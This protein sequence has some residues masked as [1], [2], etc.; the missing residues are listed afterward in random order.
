MLRTTSSWRWAL[1]RQKFRF[2]ELTKKAS[3][4]RTAC[5]LP[6]PARP[7]SVIII[8]GGV[9]GIEFATLFNTLGKKVTVIEMLPKIM[10][11]TDAEIST[12]MQ[13]VLKK[14]GIEFHLNAKVI[15]IEE[16]MKVIYEEKGKECVAEGEQVVVAIGRK[17]ATAGMGLEELGIQMNRGFVEVDDELRTSVPNIFA[18]GDITGKIQLAHVA[19]AQG[20][21]AAANAAGANKKMDYNIVPSCIYTAPEIG[22]VGLTE[23][24]AKEK[25]LDVKVGKFN[26]AANG[27]SMIIGEN[28]GMAKIVADAKT[29]EVYGA[30]IMAPRATDMITEIAVAMKAEATIETIADT[31]HPHPTVSEIIMEAAHDVEGLCCHKM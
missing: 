21:V 22:S 6:I 1:T 11:T 15:G 30:A 24:Q 16:G 17:P 20:M 19:S 8:G 31:I 5:L 18:I 13:R 28:T 3:P 14:R 27:R 9:I 25:G 2:P 7:E 23:E 4:I 10:G 26:I 12:M 29:G